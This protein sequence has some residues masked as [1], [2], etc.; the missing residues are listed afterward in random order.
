MVSMNKKL[1]D[2]IRLVDVRNKD[3]SITKL[4][5]VSNEKYFMPSIANIVGTDLSS[6]KVVKYNQ[7]AYGPVTSR[8]GDKISIALLKEDECIVSSSY[9]VFEIVNEELLNPDYLMMW[10]KRP[11]FDRY[12]RFISHG[13]VRELF[14][15]EKMCDVELPIP[16][17]EKQL[18]IISDYQTIVDRIAIK[19]E[20]NNNLFKQLSAKFNLMFGDLFEETDEKEMMCVKDLG[21]IICGKTPSTEI[22]E[23]FG[24]DIPFI[25]IP[26][27]HNNVF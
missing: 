22:K 19:E 2:Y 13:S 5:G 1:G 17:L 24:G 9:V 10:F 27:M 25:T 16:S 26:D 18:S 6:Y 14:P 11:E 20:I 3:L 21:Q 4:L 12:C 7:F 8:N 15:W 23:Y